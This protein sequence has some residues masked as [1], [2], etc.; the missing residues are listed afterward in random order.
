MKRRPSR[1]YHTPTSLRSTTS[2]GSEEKSTSR[3]NWSRARA[4]GDGSTMGNTAGETSSASWVEAG[5]GLEA[6]HAKGI[7]HRDFKPANVL[8][9]DD[10]RVRVLDFG[11]A[12]SDRL[13]DLSASGISDGT[14]GPPASLES[15]SSQLPELTEVGAVMGTPAYM[16]P[17][18]AAGDPVDA[19]SDQ[20]S[21]CVSLYEGLFGIRPFAGAHRRERLRNARL[22]RVRTPPPQS[23][24][25]KRVE[26]AILRGLAP[27]P[28]ARWSSLAALLDELVRP[29]HPSWPLGRRHRDR[30]GGCD[31]GGDPGHTGIGRVRR[32]R[33]GTVAAVERHLKDDPS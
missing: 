33:L 24:V 3:W 1:G 26:Q 15:G 23:P 31:R 14:S 20:F 17:E 12:R 32:R 10:G 27:D 9:G 4:C 16:A 7:V 6:A 30:G 28:Q 25:P 21:F 19:R 29:A 22:G 8:L 2:G 13:S 5:R 11:L 18:Q